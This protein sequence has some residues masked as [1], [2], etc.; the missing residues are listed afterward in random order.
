MIINKLKCKEMEIVKTHD[1]ELE[2]KVKPFG[3]VDLKDLKIYC[4]KC[5]KLIGNLKTISNLNERNNFVNMKWFCPECL[6]S[7]KDVK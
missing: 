2:H 4:I 3:E 5:G 6:N 1:G 7:L